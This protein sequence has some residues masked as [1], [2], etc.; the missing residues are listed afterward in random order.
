MKNQYLY[1]IF[2]SFLE[3]RDIVH[4]KKYVDKALEEFYEKGGL[5]NEESI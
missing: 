5:K 3:V 1:K 2:L 4:H